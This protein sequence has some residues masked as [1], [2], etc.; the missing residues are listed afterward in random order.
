MKRLIF[1]FLILTLGLSYTIPAFSAES[2]TVP[3][4]QQQIQKLKAENEALKKENQALRKQMLERQS[5][6]APSTVASP[7]VQKPTTASAEKHWITNSSSKRH[8]SACRYYMNS[9]GRFCGPNEGIACK[10]CGG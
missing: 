10:I 6:A 2:A 4:L 8:N 1:A 5:S 9:K 7:S 3:E